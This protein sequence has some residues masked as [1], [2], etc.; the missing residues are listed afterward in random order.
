MRSLKFRIGLRHLG[1][2]FAQPKIELPEQPLA[3]PDLQLYPELIA[4][5]C[6]QDRAIPHLNGEAKLCRT[7]A[8]RRFDLGQLAFI[9]SARSSRPL[10]FGQSS[11]PLRFKSLHP[12]HHRPRRV[13]Q[14]LGDLRAS[15]AL[16]DQQYSMQ[17]VIIT[18]HVIA[19][20]LIL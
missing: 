14:A 20:N 4:E 19:A 16:R 12:I 6:R 5:K 18:R 8:Q 1:P 9:Q 10:S 7:G 11:E 13:A 2:R 15:H 3:L 17:S